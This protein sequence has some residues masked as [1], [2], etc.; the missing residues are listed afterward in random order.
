LQ[1]KRKAILL[2]PQLLNV[3]GGIPRHGQ[4]LVQ[5][6]QEWCR[7]RD[8]HVE[9]LSLNDS[10]GD[11]GRCGNDTGVMVRG[12][13]CS[14]LRFA[15]AGAAS[16]CQAESGILIIGLANFLPIVPLLSAAGKKFRIGLVVH[17][18]EVWNRLSAVSR[19]GLRFVDHV[20]AVSEFTRNRFCEFNG[21]PIEQCEV[22]SNTLDPSW[23]SRAQD[24]DLQRPA[25]LRSRK[26]LLSVARLDASESYKGI[27]QVLD[28]LPLIVESFPDV[29]YCVIGDGTDRMRLEQF[30][31][32]KKI[33]RYVNFLGRVSEDTLMSYYNWCDVFLLPS[34]GEGFGLVYLEAMACG[35]PVIAGNHGGAPEVVDNGVTGYLVDHDDVR[36][37]TKVI[38]EL[39]AND[40]LR[41]SMGKAGRECGRNIF[42]YRVLRKK[43]IR[44]FD[45]LLDQ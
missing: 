18:I 17:G 21:Y 36:S 39:L 23:C 38:S 33:S 29:I 3:A 2:H 5:Y 16:V 9:L 25:E 31:E 1:Q 44:F 4:C 7:S 22:I 28:A 37:L 8:L 20:V 34:Q 41:E 11:L 26:V 6:L 43:W 45:D 35:K 30:A 40:S 12:F 10:S 27:E 24:L 32:Q 15:G 42:G 19:F 13:D 14:R